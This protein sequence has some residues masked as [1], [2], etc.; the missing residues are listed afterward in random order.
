MR[1]QEISLNVEKLSRAEERSC[2][3][4]TAAQD[5]W[6]YRAGTGRLGSQYGHHWRA[7]K[8]SQSHSMETSMETSPV[9]QALRTVTS[10][11]TTS[12]EVTTAIDYDQMSHILTIMVTISVISIL[13]LIISVSTIFVFLW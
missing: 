7:D 3:R 4:A 10:P 5:G 2:L 9:L 8:T 1:R 12:S 6:S 13:I 11:D